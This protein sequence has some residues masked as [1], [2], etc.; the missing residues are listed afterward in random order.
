MVNNLCDFYNLLGRLE[1]RQY[2]ETFISYNVSLINAKL[3]PSITLTVKK[4]D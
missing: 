1:G 4:R 2:I 3:K